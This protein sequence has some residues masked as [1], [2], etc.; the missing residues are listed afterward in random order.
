MIDSISSKK[1]REREGIVPPLFFFKLECIHKLLLLL[2]LGDVMDG[3]RRMEQA[4]NHAPCIQF[5]FFPDLTT[6]TTTAAPASS[7]LQL[8]I[9]KYFHGNSITSCMGFYENLCLVFIQRLIDHHTRARRWIVAG[10]IR[11]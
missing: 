10:W 6:T 11:G 2:H 8:A 3:E 7:A 9:R 1:K 5:G 4:S